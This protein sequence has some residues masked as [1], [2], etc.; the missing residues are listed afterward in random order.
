[1]FSIV[2]IIKQ[3]KLYN[4]QISII[5]L[6]TYEKYHN[7]GVKIIGNIYLSL[8]AIYSCGWFIF[9]IERNMTPSIL[10]KDF[11]IVTERVIHQR[12]L[13]KLKYDN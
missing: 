3:N 13:L 8:G 7:K 10:T 5:S 4:C 9:G 6:L 2:P 1:M 12:K 11:I